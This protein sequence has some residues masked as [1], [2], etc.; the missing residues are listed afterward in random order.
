MNNVTYSLVEAA[1]LIE[2]LSLTICAPKQIY[3][4]IKWEMNSN[5]RVVSDLESIDLKGKSIV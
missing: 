4:Q 3:S 2:E 1:N 5:I